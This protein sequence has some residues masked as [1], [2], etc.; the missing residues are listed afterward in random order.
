MHS[1]IDLYKQLPPYPGNSLTLHLDNIK[2]LIE[3]TKSKTALDYGCG[4]A[5]HYIKDR[6]HLSWGLDKMGL[7]DPAVLEWNSLPGDN[8]D[9]VISTDVL[10]HVP[11]QEINKTL[12]QNNLSQ[13]SIQQVVRGLQSAGDSTHLQNREIPITNDHIVQDEEVKPNFVPEP[14]N[15]NYI[16]SEQSSIEHMIQKSKE[17]N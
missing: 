11:E 10:E 15:D 3:T 8:F 1:K 17:K 16:E 9:C 4:K 6:I 13:D 7:Y 14:E 5:Q 12:E 2:K